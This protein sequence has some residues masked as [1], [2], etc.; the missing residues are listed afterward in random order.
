MDEIQ[1]QAFVEQLSIEKFNRPFLHQ[2][3][4]NKRLKSTGGR[5]LLQSHNIELNYKLYEHFGLEELRGIILHELCH[6]HLHIQN[7]GYKHR[8]LDFRK[9]LKQVGA[10]RFCSSLPIKEK[11]VKKLYIYQCNECNLLYKR[12][13]KVNIEKY[14]CGKCS[15]KL[16]NISNT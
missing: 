2:A 8:D 12:R 4:F 7:K 11:V 1:L 15:G 6:Y 13:R 9:L 10:P 3:Y 5:Y 14:R 16:R